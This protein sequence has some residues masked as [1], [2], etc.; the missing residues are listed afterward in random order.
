M[1]ISK[2]S[3]YG[4]YKYN[5]AKIMNKKNGYEPENMMVNYSQNTGKPQKEANSSLYS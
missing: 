2:W 4:V 1:R 3:E 5:H